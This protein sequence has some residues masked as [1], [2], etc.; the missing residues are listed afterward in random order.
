MSVLLAS[1][2]VGDGNR[3]P[4]RASE[5]LAG[6]QA[7][8]EKAFA[9][10][11]SPC[12]LKQTIAQPPLLR[13]PLRLRCCD[14]R[15]RA[16]RSWTGCSVAARLGTHSGGVGKSAARSHGAC[17][18]VTAAAAAALPSPAATGTGTPPG[19]G[20][21]HPLHIRVSAR[22]P[23]SARACWRLPA[24]LCCLGCLGGLSARRQRHRG[25]LLVS[26]A[27]R[28][29]GCS[30]GGWEVAGAPLGTLDALLVQGSARSRAHEPRLAPP[31]PLPRATRSCAPPHTLA[32]V[33]CS[34][35]GA[36]AAL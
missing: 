34:P 23:R 1:S 22:P 15:R 35:R 14:K 2:S 16:Q 19:A 31:A 33:R 8:L 12:D 26:V 27:H 9:N 10:G 4:L 21:L 17:A 32:L 11:C 18:R 7:R 3:E 30:E 13:A 20:F 36:C 24:P 25:V 5:S 28:Q 6:A 29:L